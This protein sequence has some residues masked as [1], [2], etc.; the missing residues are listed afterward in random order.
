MNIPKL[1]DDF[2]FFQNYQKKWKTDYY[3]IK[4]NYNH[5]KFFKKW[6]YLD[7]FNQMVQPKL[8]KYLKGTRNLKRNS[9]DLV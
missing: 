6:A 2:S 4:S 1:L 5:R 3:N 9:R 7:A 8:E